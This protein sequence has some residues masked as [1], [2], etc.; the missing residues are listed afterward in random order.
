V[1]R[2]EKEVQGCQLYPTCTI[3]LHLNT[4]S[5]EYPNLSS[6]DSQEEIATSEFT[7]IEVFV[8]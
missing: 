7:E 5:M 6:D 4:S 2:G 8:Y 3:F 1:D